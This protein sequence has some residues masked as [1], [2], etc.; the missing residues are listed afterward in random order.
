VA[1]NSALVTRASNPRVV[2]AASMPHRLR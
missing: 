2:M 1:A